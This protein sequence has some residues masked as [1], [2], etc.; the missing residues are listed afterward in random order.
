VTFTYK[1]FNLDLRYYDTNLSRENCFVFT[2]D[3]NARPGGRVDL[4][5]NPGWLGLE[6]VQCNDRRQGLVCVLVSSFAGA[7]LI[8]SSCGSNSSTTDRSRSEL[9]EASVLR[10]QTKRLSSAMGHLR[11]LDYTARTSSLPLTADAKASVEVR[12]YGPKNEMT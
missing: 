7:L 10:V 5:T 12:L 3:P 8:L 11:R 4:I 6:L 9:I 2:G 1:V